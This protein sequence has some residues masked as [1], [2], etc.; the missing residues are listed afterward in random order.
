MSDRWLT[1]GECEIVNLSAVALVRLDTEKK[2]I[3]FFL[4][5]DR[6]ATIWGFKNEEN[7][8]NSFRTIEKILIGREDDSD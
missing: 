5:N 6:T 3:E 7:A 2:E 1:D 8:S 4:K